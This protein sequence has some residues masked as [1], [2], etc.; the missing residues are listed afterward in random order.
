MTS[1]FKPLVSLIMPVWKPHPPWLAAAVSSALDQSSVRLE[2]IVVDDGSPQPVAELL[3]RYVDDRRLRIVRLRVN[4]GG[5]QAR[6]A[7]IEMARGD[8][9]RFVDADDVCPRGSTAR[10]V[11]LS[12]GERVITYGA[13]LF[14]DD[15]LRPVWSMRSRVDGDAVR[16]CLLGR[17]RVRTPAALFPRDVVHA[18]G[19]WDPS[20]AVST[21]WDFTLRCLEHAPVRGDGTVALLYRRHAHSTT[22]DLAGG[23]AG[24]RRV[25][26]RYFERHPEQRGT[27]LER[28]VEASIEAMLARVDATHGEPVSA[29]RRTLRALA[30]DPTAIAHELRHSWPALGS[31]ARRAVRSGLSA[32]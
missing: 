29:A 3:G 24:A 25:A 32:R 4:A 13:T 18:A 7:G 14:C 16:R 2:V 9:L 15:A 11:S 17:F 28:Q 1:K 30:T 21:D 20:F 31:R 10:L 8:L 26:E 5:A 19:R 27:W 23:E 12:G 22:S 6:N